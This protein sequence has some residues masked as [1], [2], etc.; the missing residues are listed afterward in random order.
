MPRHILLAKKITAFSTFFIAQW[1]IAVFA[2][3]PLGGGGGT[4]NSIAWPTEQPET[5]HKTVF[6][7]KVTLVPSR[8]IRSVLV[9]KSHVL[10]A[11]GWTAVAMSVFG[12]TVAA[13]A[14]G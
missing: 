1:L 10:L 8:K 11:M 13:S 4:K 5:N 3:L 9:L 6:T 12:A 14:A 7:S 2:F